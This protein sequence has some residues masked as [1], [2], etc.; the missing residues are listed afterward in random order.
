M[1]RDVPKVAALVGGAFA[2][3]ALLLYMALQITSNWEQA[4]TPGEKSLGVAALGM[5]FGL[6]MLLCAGAAV[7]SFV[8]GLVIFPFSRRKLR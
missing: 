3:L 7:L 5:L 1:S 4:Q 6:P 8:V 2:I